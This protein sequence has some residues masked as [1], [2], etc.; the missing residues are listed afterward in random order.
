MTLSKEWFAAKWT[1]IFGFRS[2]VLNINVRIFKTNWKIK[3]CSL[4]YD[5]INILVSYYK[6]F[7]FARPFSMWKNDEERQV[8][9]DILLIHV[10]DFSNQYCLK[11]YWFLKVRPTKYQNTNSW[12]I[13]DYTLHNPFI[14]LTR[15]KKT[16][17]YKYSGVKLSPLSSSSSVWHVMYFLINAGHICVH[18]L[19]GIFAG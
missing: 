10:N 16:G 6:S 1:K 8:S 18:V 7:A 3:L 4:F 11:E 5:M 15:T 12:N 17:K 19:M 2:V 9:L 14:V 13:L